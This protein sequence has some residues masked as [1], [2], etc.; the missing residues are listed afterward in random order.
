MKAFFTNSG[1]MITSNSGKIEYE[2]QF[3]SI[4][5]KFKLFAPTGTKMKDYSGYRIVLEAND[6]NNPS[7]KLRYIF[8]F[9]EIGEFVGEANT[10]AVGT[11]GTQEVTRTADNVIVDLSTKALAEA[12]VSG[13]I[14]YAR[15]YLTDTYGNAVDPTGILTV[16]YNSAAATNL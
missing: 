16:Q 3:T 10:S 6:E 7:V 11:G 12:K 5:G 4:L 15:F 1:G 13:D 2:Y 14:K 8:K 9:P